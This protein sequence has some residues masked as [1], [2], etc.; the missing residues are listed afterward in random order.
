MAG[1]EAVLCLL[2]RKAGGIWG[3]AVPARM[4]GFEAVLCL[5]HRKAGGIWGQVVHARMAG[6]ETVLRHRLNHRG[7]SRLRLRW[8]L[9]DEQPIRYHRKRL[10][11]HPEDHSR[12][13]RDLLGEL[14]LQ[15]TLLLEA[16]G[17]L[18]LAQ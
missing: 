6:F 3:Q 15:E 5:L 1:F 10:P 18:L 4:A 12:P 17:Q 8:S 9:L 11:S 14:L 13:V 16:D 2:H 7:S